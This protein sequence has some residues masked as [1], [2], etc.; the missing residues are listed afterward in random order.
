MPNPRGGQYNLVIPPSCTAGHNPPLFIAMH[1]TP[2]DDNLHPDGIQPTQRRTTTSRTPTAQRGRPRCPCA[3]SNNRPRHRR[4]ARPRPSGAPPATIFEPPGF[5]FHP[6]QRQV[7][8]LRPTPRPSSPALRSSESGGPGI[9]DPP[10]LDLP[11]RHQQRSSSLPAS[12]S[13]PAQRQVHRLRPTPRP[14]SPALRSSE[15][16]GYQ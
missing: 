11:A 15:S 7:H 9:D 4:P 3:A 5:L 12:C 6:G 10:G 2:I 14:S 16:G 1:T 8:R 13:T